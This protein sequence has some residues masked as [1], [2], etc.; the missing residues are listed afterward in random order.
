MA[1]AVVNGA[2]PTDIGPI[3]PR[4]GARFLSGLATAEGRLEIGAGPSEPAG[5]IEADMLDDC[6]TCR[7]SD[8]SKAAIREI[9]ADI[10]SESRFISARWSAIC[11]LSSSVSLA[12]FS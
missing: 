6:W 8:T 4:S 2:P 12:S 1:D 9:S 5:G 3:G 10:W 11:R 7:S